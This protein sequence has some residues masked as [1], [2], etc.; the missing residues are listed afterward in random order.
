MT[1][2]PGDVDHET[3]SF[4]FARRNSLNVRGGNV[5]R[6]QLYTGNAFSSVVT[7]TALACNLTPSLSGTL[8]A[9][10]SATC[11]L[12]GAAINVN[13]GSTAVVV[14]SSTATGFGPLTVV[15]MMVSVGVG[16]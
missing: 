5:V 8:P 2:N 4:L 9:G 13:A 14:I 10:T 1:E 16:P 11:L 7:P 3:Q 12:T 6:A 15:P